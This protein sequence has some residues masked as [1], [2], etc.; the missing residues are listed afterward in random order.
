MGVR[1][2]KRSTMPAK[3]TYGFFIRITHI[4]DRLLRCS[5]LAVGYG[6]WCMSECLTTRRAAFLR[7]CLM[8]RFVQA[9]GAPIVQ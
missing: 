9:S 3:V 6:T 5:E 2:E 8:N 7:G 4:M 1:E